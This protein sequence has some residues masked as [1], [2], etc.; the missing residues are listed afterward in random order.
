VD[1]APLADPA[2]GDKLAFLLQAFEPHLVLTDP[3]GA[4]D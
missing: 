3:P 2:E 4:P 1:L